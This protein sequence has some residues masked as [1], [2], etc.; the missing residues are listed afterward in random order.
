MLLVKILRLTSQEGTAVIEKVQFAGEGNGEGNQRTNCK[1]TWPSPVLHLLVL[2]PS[3][4]SAAQSVPPA[5]SS[6]SA[7]PPPGPAAL[8]PGPS[9]AP[10]RGKANSHCSFRHEMHRHKEKLHFN[11]CRA[12]M[13]DKAV[14]HRAPAATGP[15]Y[16][17]RL[18]PRLFLLLPPLTLLLQLVQA[19]LVLLE[20]VQ[21]IMPLVL[22]FQRVDK[23]DFVH[24]KTIRKWKERPKKLK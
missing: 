24:L 7:A 5:P 19:L 21:H 8:L 14:L 3:L 9:C 4:A 15:P 16:L 2:F 17:N 12:Q 23:S 11:V 10:A 22:S 1:V 6:S 18:V 13:K 20:L